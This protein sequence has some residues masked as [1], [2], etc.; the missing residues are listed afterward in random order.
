MKYN[1]I[2]VNGDIT[3]T[4]VET[5]IQYI[6]FDGTRTQVINPSGSN[7]LTQ[8]K[9]IYVYSGKSIIIEKTNI[10]NCSQGAYLGSGATVYRGGLFQKNGAAFAA[11]DALAANNYLGA[12]SLDQI[13]E[14]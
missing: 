13:V 3:F 5:E 4:A 7:K 8:L 9:G 10:I 6:E 12:W 11:N 2:I 14:Y 1:T